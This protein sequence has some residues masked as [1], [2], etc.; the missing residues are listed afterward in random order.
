MRAHE[1]LEAWRMAHQL[2]L[3][4]YAATDRWPRSEQFGVTAQLRRAAI[5]VLQTSLKD[6]PD[7]DAASSRGS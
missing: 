5:S 6:R 3:E 7:M 4:V 1:R 2:A